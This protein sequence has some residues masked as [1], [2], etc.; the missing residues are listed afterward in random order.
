MAAEDHSKKILLLGAGSSGKS[1]F[2]RQLQQHYNNKSAEIGANAIRNTLWRGIREIPDIMQKKVVAI[3]EEL[4]AAISKIVDENDVDLIAAAAPEFQ[5]LAQSSE[6]NNF[7][8][9]HSDDFQGVPGG[10][11]LLSYLLENAERILS[12]DYEPSKEDLVRNRAHTSGITETRISFSGNEFSIID[13]GGRRNER[14]K[15]IHCF[16]GVSLIVFFCPMDDHSKKLAEDDQTNALQ[17][18]I[19]LFT[20][21][22]SSQ[23]FRNTKFFVV[24]SKNDLFKKALE[25]NSIGKNFPEFEK[26]SEDRK[27]ESVEEQGLFLFFFF[28]VFFGSFFFF[29]SF[30]SSSFSVFLFF[31]F[32]CL[33]F[34]AFFSLCSPLSFLIFFSL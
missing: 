34:F 3:S 12:S 14:K 1:T 27:E 19:H 29:L 21:L 23:F 20:D 4:T 24:F 15:W 8:A 28:S 13:V 2:V 32:F 16:D 10:A 6:F 33:F 9:Q 26:F 22:K 5:F 25:R 30:F 31:V 17:E 18:S 11:F 7:I